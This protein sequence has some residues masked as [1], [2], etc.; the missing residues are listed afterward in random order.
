MEIVFL[1]RSNFEVL[2]FGY[3][4]NEYQIII[5]SVIPQKSIFLVNKLNINASIGDLL[6]VKDKTINYIGIICSIEEDKTSHKT[7]V[8][9]NDFI[10]VLDVKVKLFN[11]SGNLSIYLCNLINSA[12]ITN[13]DPLQRFNYLSISR[14]FDSINGT[15]TFETDTIDTISSLVNTLSKAYSIGIKYNIVFSDIGEYVGIELHIS[16]CKN[17]L[18]LKSTLADIKDLSISC[19]NEQSI[20]KISFIPSDENTSY[21]NM[22][23]YYLLSDGQVT[24]N[25]NDSKRIQNLSSETKVYKDS[26]YQSLKTTAQ[27]EMLI[28]SLEHSIEFNIGMDNKI[29]KPFIDIN[30]GDYLEFIT[31]NKT[32]TTMVSQFILKNTTKQM[33]V[34]LGEYRMKLTDKIKLLTRK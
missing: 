6:T 5:D 33:S 12:L 28:S 23:S 25:A 31:P 26:D 30:V 18:I 29:A 11:Y 24:T 34:V 4:D 9:T 13:V 17:G 20:N 16:S 10:S 32:F 22:V 3:V 19:S 27:N 2:D 14:D 7:K 21:R 1:K 8:Q 15:L